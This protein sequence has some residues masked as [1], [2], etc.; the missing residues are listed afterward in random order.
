M[1]TTPQYVTK[2]K[3]ENEYNSANM[4]VIEKIENEVRANHESMFSEDAELE[5]KERL[6][7]DLPDYR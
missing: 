3:F 4:Q 5:F 7:E 2:A 1:A 6:R